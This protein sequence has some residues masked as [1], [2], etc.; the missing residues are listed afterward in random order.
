LINSTSLAKIV[1]IKKGKKE[2]ESSLYSDNRKRY[3]QIE[4]LRTNQNI[5]F[6]TPSNKSVEVCNDDVLIAWDG[7]NA[8]TVGFQLAGIIGSTLA[9]LRVDTEKAYP[10]YLGRY[11]QFRFPEI[12]NN[13]TGATIPHVS[14][15]HLREL[16]V[17]LPPLPEQKRIATILDKADVLRDKRKKSIAKLDELLQSVFHDMFGDPL[18][19]SDWC[20]VKVEALALPVKGSIRTGPFGS[21]LLHSEFVDD[22]IAVL[23]IDNAVNNTFRWGER[24]YITV[25]KYK[26]LK[27]Y[28]VKPGDVLI[29][30]MGTC[31][32][33]AIVPDDIPLA[34]NTK[35]L[36]SITLNKEIC[37]P[38][39]L[40]SCFLMHKEVLKQLGISQK[41][42]VM[43]GLNMQIIKNLKVPLPPISLQEKYKKRV[44]R[45]L[46]L[47]RIH[48]K[49]DELS[50]NSFFSLQQR[51]FRG[52]L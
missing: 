40:H 25:E 35:H 1:Q 37:L 9:R 50:R 16:S 43:P 34:I 41:G 13:C 20:Q 14:G 44:S 21:Q 3:L 51:A 4:D 30:I 38:E 22:G 29:T 5:K 26:I 8:G 15:H 49:S 36:C 19:S 31:G 2:Q 7:A 46:E 6:C 28:T 42:A 47:R 24:R 52:E 39:Y 32:R 33:C 48:E 23:G 45:I 18:A 11:L 27:K 10:Q 17:P 12:R